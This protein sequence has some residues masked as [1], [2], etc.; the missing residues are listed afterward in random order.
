MKK[1]LTGF[2]LFLTL[3]LAAFAA[4]AERDQNCYTIVVGKKASADGSVI[5][6]HNEDDSGDIIVNLR[7]I[8]ARDYGAPQRVDLGWGAVYET[9]GKTNEFLW[10]ETA[11]QEFADSFVNQYGVLVTSDSCSSKATADDVTDGGIGYM[12]RRIVAEKARSAKEAAAIAGELVEKFGYI[13]SGRTYTIADKNEA[14]MVQIIKGRHWFAERIP[15][16][17]MA[18]IPNHFTIRATHPEDKANFMGSRDIVDYARNNGWYDE[19]K[20]GPFDFKKA[21][22]RPG[23]QDLVLDGNVLRHWRG[24]NFFSDK[25]WEIS[26]SYP[27]SFK[28]AKKVAA[29]SLMAVLR[30]HYEGTE[31]DATEGY[32]KGT[33]NSTKFRC[34]CTATTINSFIASLNAGL[35]DPIS[36]S[37]WLA[38]GRPDTTAYLPVY[39]GIEALPPGAGLGSRVHDYPLFYKQHFDDAE[40]K[41]RRDQLLHT[42][43]L[44]LQKMGETEYA[45]VREMTDREL[46][47]I[48]KEFIRNKKAL[49]SDVAAVYAKDKTEARRKLT[50]YV[51]D[52]FGKISAVYERILKDSSGN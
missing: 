7:K 12:L 39:Y 28:P 48:E 27:F 36:V 45:R 3:G 24:L 11:G 51:A 5:V 26:N 21:F 44:R 35:P 16:D 32:K 52:A 20:D 17:E 33:P 6:G 8:Q 19:T 15:D 31:Y 22:A 23:R 29:E 25:K 2:L 47:P 1:I 42:K 41:A 50:A 9:D 37:L 14:W 34:I 13:G 38:V 4:A 46:S 43:I 30:D 40:W 49:E 18:V 10:I